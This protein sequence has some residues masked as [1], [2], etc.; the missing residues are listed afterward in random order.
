MKRNNTIEDEYVEFSVY[1]GTRSNRETIDHQYLPDTK[2]QKSVMWV[3][4]TKIYNAM[5]NDHLVDWL[6]QYGKNMLNRKDSI[7]AKELM[8]YLCKRGIDFEAEVDKYIKT[9]CHTE[10]VTQYYSID[11]VEQTKQYMQQGVPVILSASVAN[12][13]SATFG[14]ADALVRSDY[15]NVIFQNPVIS[16]EESKIKAPKLSG[17]YHYRVVEVKYSTLPLTSSNNIQ[18]QP[19]KRK[20]LTSVLQKRRQMR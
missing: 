6:N 16:E 7:E 17:Q 18:N 10:S 20:N 15:L 14:I 3:S 12:I 13:S 1:R 9:K 4:A 2:K 5:T 8:D 19:N 11:A